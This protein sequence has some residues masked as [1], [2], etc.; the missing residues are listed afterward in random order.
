MGLSVKAEAPERGGNQLLL[1]SQQ[2]RAASDKWWGAPLVQSP[3]AEQLL[4]HAR[5][6]A[7]T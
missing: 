6:V 3:G 7:A 4:E 2:C 1:E 5:I